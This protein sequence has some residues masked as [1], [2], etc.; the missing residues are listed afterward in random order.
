VPVAEVLATAEQ[1]PVTRAYFR[2]L[3]PSPAAAPMRGQATPAD[4][5]AAAAAADDLVELLREAEVLSPAQ[6][7]ALL[8]A[9]ADEDEPGDRLG[10]ALRRLAG[11][12][13]DQHARRMAELAYLTNA[14]HA[15]CSFEGRRFRPA[16]AARAAVAMVNLG[17]DYCVEAGERSPDVTLARGVDRLFRVGYRLLVDEVALPVARG[18]LERLTARTALDRRP[19]VVL[20]RSIATLRAGI[21]AGKPWSA[22]AHLG[23][24][25][26]VVSPAILAAIDECPHRAVTGTDGRTSRAKGIAF[27]STRAE[28]VALR[29]SCVALVRA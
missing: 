29:N 3:G 27:V 8:A 12:A 21:T 9:P 17:L 5:P 26:D 4:A 20:A 11:R 7:V 1:D 6:A 2:T 24:L 19:D 16:E 18:L 25:S 22:R 28:L 23:G 13:A 10:P 14:L 15:G